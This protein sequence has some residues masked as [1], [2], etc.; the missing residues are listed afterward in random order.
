MTQ[1]QIY[2]KNGTWEGDSWTVNAPLTLSQQINLPQAVSI[3]NSNPLNIVTSYGASIIGS[4][5]VVGPPVNIAVNAMIFEINFGLIQTSGNIN[6]AYGFITGFGHI[7]T[8]TAGTPSILVTGWLPVGIRPLSQ[9]RIPVSGAVGPVAQPTTLVFQFETNGDV[10]I[11]KDTIGTA[12]NNADT[13]SINV[14]T[15][16]SFKISL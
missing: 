12:W 16:F 8:L 7:G 10:R 11:F 13:F 2:A 15:D 9:R 3:P 14:I 5:A 6:M 4:P 1:N